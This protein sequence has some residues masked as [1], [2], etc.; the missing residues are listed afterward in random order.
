MTIT[1]DNVKSAIKVDFGP[2]EMNYLG[3]VSRAVGI[4]LS[5][6]GGLTKESPYLLIRV[7]QLCSFAEDTCDVESMVSKFG[8]EKKLSKLES[9]PQAARGIIRNGAVK[10]IS[11]KLP[12]GFFMKKD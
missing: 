8:I 6:F 11:E 1:F 10:F 3:R 5:N 7:E 4:P 2:T 9:M 12:K